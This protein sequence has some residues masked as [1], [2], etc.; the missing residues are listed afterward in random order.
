MTKMI[1]NIVVVL[2]VTMINVTDSIAQ[3]SRIAVPR[4][5]ALEKISTKKYKWELDTQAMMSKNPFKIPPTK[6]INRCKE[7]VD[8][9]IGLAQTEDLAE[10]F[11]FQFPIVGPLGKE[12]Y[13]SAVGGFS[14][15]QMFPNFD[16]GLYYDFRVDPYQTNRVWFTA[17]FSANHAGEVCIDKYPSLSLCKAVFTYNYYTLPT[18]TLRQ[19]H[20]Q[21]CRVP[22][23]INLSHIQ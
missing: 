6:L 8:R 22:P 13:L 12:E 1:F 18:G 16:E 9:G 19:S 4:G 5:T 21:A 14:L 10:D 15:G 23:S 3:N 2:L 20:R 17:T 7:V 11:V